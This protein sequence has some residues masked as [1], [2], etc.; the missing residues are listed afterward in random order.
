MSLI[1]LIVPSYGQRALSGTPEIELALHKLNVLGS[2]LMIAAH[3]DDENTA[4]LAYMARG[5]SMRTGYLSLTRGEGGQ[6]LIGPQQ[7]DLLGVIRTQEL[8]AARRIDGAEQFFTRAIDF[9]YSKTADEALEKWGRDKVLSDIVWVIRKFRP[10]IIILRFS[11]TPRDGHGHHQASAILGKEAFSAAADKNRFP[12]QLRYVQPWQAKRLFW[13]VFS[14]TPEQE[15]E[16]AAI[17]HK[18][19]VDAGEFNPILGKSYAEIA[20]ISRSQ[21]RSQGFGA[22]ERR[23]PAKNFLATV[24]GDPAEHDPFD[25]VDTTWSR[26]AGGEAVAPILAEAL[27][28]FVP[29]EPEKTIPL[30]LKARTLIAAIDDPWAKRKL[31]ELDETLALCSGLWVDATAERYAVV[32][33]SSVKITLEA[34]NRS[35]YRVK[36]RGES[37]NT[38]VSSHVEAPLMAYNEP[39][40]R[41][42]TWTVPVDASYSQPFWLRRPPAG[43]TYDIRDQEL[44]GLPDSP[45]D[46][47]ATFSFDFGGTSLTLKRPV[48]YRYVDPTEGELTRAVV[49][50]P[51]VAVDLAEPVDV[52]PNE[53]AKRIEVTVKAST[54]DMNGEVR[55]DLPANWRAEPATHSFRLAQ[56]GDEQ[57]VAFSVTP[58]R[59]D[60]QGPLRAV[61]HVDGKEISSGDTIIAFPH[62]PPQ[63]LFPEA[64]A[65][66]ERVNVKLT[67]HRIGYVMGAGDE[68]PDAL[69]QLGCEV[70]LLTGRDLA[71]GDLAGFDAIVTGV[72]AYNVRADLRANQQRLLDYVQNGGTMIVQ[73]NVAEGGPFGGRRTGQ[74]EH[75]G[76]YPLKID[77]PRVSVEEA[78]VKFIHPDNPLLVWPNHITEHDFEGWIQERG[79]YFAS[80]WD[81][82][83]QPIVETHDPGE[84]PLQGGTLYTRYGKGVY[85]F[86][87]FSWFR[88]LPAGVPGAYRIFANMLSARGER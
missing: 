84:K 37:L 5:R 68:V 74:L 24:A 85:I 44:I 71:E 17:P 7:G 55:L 8:L 42:V 50:V 4:V 73:Y 38:L 65:K 83:Y 34:I 3:P 43:N 61:A 69:R 58:P 16:A 10:D 32:P 27:K 40:H 19:E 48:R 21:H 14:F 67:A 64:A 87:A 1:S 22:A 52:F 36:W 57:T 60:A 41:E 62:I 18:V 6:N 82:H 31:E 76:P 12:E 77:R 80:E 28:T 86:T 20:G 72:R 25:G 56:A 70:T 2:V 81:A 75:I 9:G 66:L 63:T 49:I 13:N 51:E 35:H 23:G 54:A 11:G 39:V 78:P 46:V 29:G 26:V 45:P 15:K 33:G 88:E 30:L 53:S 79:L 47:A 59:E